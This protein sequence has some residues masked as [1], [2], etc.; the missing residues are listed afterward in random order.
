M[1]ALIKGLV[2]LSALAFLLAVVASLFTGDLAGIPPESF[3]RACSNLAL[4]SIA[5]TLGF[6]KGGRP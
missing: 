4:V 3:S 5:L 2:G 6:S 1:Q